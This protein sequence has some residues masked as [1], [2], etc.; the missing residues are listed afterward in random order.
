MPI[1]ARWIHLGPVRAQSLQAAYR[2]YANA[3]PASGAPTVLWG[4]AAESLPLEAGHWV[5]PGEFIFALLV[6][7]RLAPGRRARWVSWGLSPLVAALRRFGLAVYLEGGAILV[8]AQRLAGGYAKECG[9]CALVL[10]H[11]PAEI[12][13]DARQ[14]LR[15]DAWLAALDRE[16]R[17]RQ[18]LAAFRASL[19][20]QY[21]WQFDT[22]WPTEAELAAIKAEFPVADTPVE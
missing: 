21:D 12:G 14:R 8:Q 13:A 1:A 5:E 20:A 10:G 22:A 4:R 2:G 16:A 3:L 11:F 9:S 15:F 6:P 7:L 17:A 19:E 18:V